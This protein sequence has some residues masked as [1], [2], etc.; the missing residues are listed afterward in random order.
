MHPSN[1]CTL[2]SKC[3]CRATRVCGVSAVGRW[4][5]ERPENTASTV[6]PDPPPGVSRPTSS[7][8]RPCGSTSTGSLNVTVHRIVSYKRYVSPDCG[9]DATITD[10][11][12]SGMAA[13]ADADGE[14]R[15]LRVND[16][17][18]DRLLAKLGIA[19]APGVHWK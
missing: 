6:L 18:A 7:L 1:S 16:P 8:S 17:E 9:A 4:L 13:L 12:T 11:T 15:I 14:L 3:I 10:S 5:C 2:Y 19:P